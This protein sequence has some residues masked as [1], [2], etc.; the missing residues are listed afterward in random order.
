MVLIDINKNMMNILGLSLGQLS[1]AALL[2]DGEVVAAVSEERFTKNKNDMEFPKESIQYCLDAGS[3]ST[4]DIDLVALGAK[5]GWPP[6]AQITKKFSHFDL[7]DYLRA[8]HEYW[9]PKLYEDKDPAWTEVFDDKLNT[10][11]YPY[12]GW[13]EIPYDTPKSDTVYR[14]FLIDTLVDLLDI[15]REKILSLDHNLCHAYYAYYGSPLQGKPA[16]VFTLDGGGGKHNAT[17][18]KV[19]NGEIERVYGTDNSTLARLYRYITLVL[20]MIPNE[21]EYKIMGMAPYARDEIAEK[22]YEIFSDIQ[23]IDG[24]DFKFHNEPPDNYF[25]FKDALE[26]CRFDGIAAGLQRY[27]EDLVTDWV[28]NAVKKFG[29]SRVMFSGGV[30][31]NIKINQRLHELDVV[32]DLFVCGSGGDESL[33]IGACYNAYYRDQNTGFDSEE[34]SHPESAIDPIES[35]YL[36]SDVSDEAEQ[37]IREYSDDSNFQVIGSV[38]ASELGKRLAD[39]CIIARCAGRMEFGA[40]ALGNRSILADPRD[41]DVVE[42]INDKIKMRDFWMPFTPT[43]LA[44]RCEDYLVNPKDIYAPYM[45]VGFD[46]TELAHEEIP[47]ALHSADK[48]ARP[49][50]LHREINPEYYDIIEAFEEETGVGALLNTSFNLHGSPIIRT[51]DDAFHVF[52]NSGLEW[53]LVDDVLVTKT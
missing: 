9:Y 33:A 7:D 35:M 23:Y 21:H 17:I 8:Q 20:G 52:E 49:Q 29:I 41:R 13:D 5:K 19:E 27:A 16:L 25:Y 4:D 45:T 50:M 1:T 18:N 10:D 51:V 26:G 32:D 30:S 31:M 22:P 47:A 11:Q 36:G 43:I 3:I 24:L 28:R 6:E 38:T 42:I 39:G 53:L 48:T 15:S 37:V 14:E 44:D 46:T 40:R 34:K 2:Q 12:Q